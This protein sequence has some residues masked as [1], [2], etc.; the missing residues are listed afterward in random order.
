MPAIARGQSSDGANPVLEL[1]TP[2]RGVLVDAAAVSFQI[3][4]VS[5]DAKRTTPVQVFPAPPNTRAAVNLAEPWPAGDKLGPGHVVARWTPAPD[6]ALGAHEIRWFVQGTAGAAE[7]IVTVDF[8]V[9]AAGAGSYRSGYALVSDLR[10]EGVA[11]A[12]AT[13]ARLARLIRLATQYV[14]RITGRFFEPR[15]MTLALDGSGGR[16]LLLGHP[17]IAIRDVTLLVAMPAEIGELPVVP[18]FFKVYNRHL[19]QGL[20]D[21]DD[22]E[23]PRLEFFHES[24]LLGVQAT[25]AASL[26][27]GSLVWLRG[28]QN[29]VVNGIFGYTDPSGSAAGHTPEL[30]RHVTKLL[31]LREIPAMTDT[32]LREDRQNR[33]RIVSERTRDQGYNLEP[34]H[35]Q[36]GFPGDPA[37]DAILASY[38]RPPHLGA[39]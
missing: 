25:P 22:R 32:S 21:P 14:D 35:A 28:V 6:E 9:L 18:S 19:T 10:A 27:L 23:N 36:G 24:D 13:D 33:W 16:I 1:F 3:F 26:G 31:V 4:D 15:P 2:S 12:E 37:I 5:D 7:Q 29:V 30:I 8:D 34:L 20:L 17:I 11:T 38:Q 39:A